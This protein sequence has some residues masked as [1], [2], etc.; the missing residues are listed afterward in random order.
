MGVGTGTIVL[1]GSLLRK[2]A[3]SDDLCLVVG[4]SSQFTNSYFKRHSKSDHFR[5]GQRLHSSSIEKTTLFIEQERQSIFPKGPGLFPIKV[6]MK[7]FFL[8]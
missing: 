7:V 5:L 4:I 2:V 1:F 3:L 6:P 8:L